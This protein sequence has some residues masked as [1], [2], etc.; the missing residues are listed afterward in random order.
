MDMS[1]Y[2]SKNDGVCYL[3][4]CIGVFSKYARVRCLKNK[5]AKQV[6]AAF[7]DILDEGRIPK[8]LQ[9]DQGKEFLNREVCSNN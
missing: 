9:T 1:T 5:S 7:K 6:A 2:S 4:T 3:L 8:K